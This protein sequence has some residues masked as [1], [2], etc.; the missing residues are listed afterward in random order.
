MFY[1]QGRI[2]FYMTNFGEEA[3]HV[4]SAAALDPEDAIMGQYREAG[5]L[6]W[7]G[8]TISDFINQCYGNIEDDGKGRQMPV[9]YGSKKLNFFTISS[10][11]GKC[12]YF[13]M[14]RIC[15]DNQHA[16]NKIIEKYSTRIIFSF[17]H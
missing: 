16:E 14:Y 13:Y 15:F 1:R 3:S 5:V 2:S 9:H 10:P 7:R 11:L 8:F 6:V 4:G 17:F 12:N